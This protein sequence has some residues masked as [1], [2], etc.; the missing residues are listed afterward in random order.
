MTITIYNVFTLRRLKCAPKLISAISRGKN[1]LNSNF[2]V[3][4]QAHIYVC[5]FMLH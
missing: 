2:K 3:G 5:E 4:S 1:Q